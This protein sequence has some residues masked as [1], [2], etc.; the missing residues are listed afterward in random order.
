M[1]ITNQFLEDLFL[2]YAAKRTDLEVQLDFQ[3]N[4]SGT[5]DIYF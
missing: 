5:K 4:R 2:T 3:L 1:A